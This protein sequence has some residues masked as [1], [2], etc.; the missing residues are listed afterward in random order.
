VEQLDVIAIRGMEGA[1]NRGGT[2]ERRVGV[3]LGVRADRRCDADAVLDLLAVDEMETEEG[4]DRSPE[5]D[6]TG[7]RQN[8]AAQNLSLG[9]AVESGS[10]VRSAAGSLDLDSKLE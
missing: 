2:E 10:Q 7:D 4:A 3:F 5:I 6:C 1:K 8:P 9:T